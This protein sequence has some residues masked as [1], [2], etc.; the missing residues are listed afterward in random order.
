[1]DAIYT[2][3]ASWFDR[4]IALGS[5][6]RSS[7]MWAAT[8]CAEL[9]Q[10]AA[11]NSR[12]QPMAFAA[13]RLNT[14]ITQLMALPLSRPDSHAGGDEPSG[15]TI[16]GAQAVRLRQQLT[17]TVEK[18]NATYHAAVTAGAE[19]S[20][21]A[22]AQVA[23]GEQLRRLGVTRNA[24]GTLAFSPA[25][26]DAQVVAETTTLAGMRESL[27]AVGGFAAAVVRAAHGV[28]GDLQLVAAAARRQLS[29]LAGEVSAGIAGQAQAMV[30]AVVGSSLNNSLSALGLGALVDLYA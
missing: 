19:E 14:T 24:D 9:V 13:N 16:S 20:R 1:M 8:V 18:F 3:A 2:A 6:V 10:Y 28:N 23:P 17:A 11:I 7:L 25:E 5:A 29:A 30:E 27:D 12:V 15:Q 4:E 21:A 26:Y 22:L